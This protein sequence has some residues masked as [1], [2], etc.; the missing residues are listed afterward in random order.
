MNKVSIEKTE[1][2]I[3]RAKK[4][5]NIS[6]ILNVK[7]RPVNIASSAA[8]QTKIEPE[9]PLLSKTKKTFSISDVL[10][11]K[12]RPIGSS[13]MNKEHLSTGCNGA[14]CE[15]R[16]STYKE[17]SRKKT[18]MSKSKNIPMTQ[19][20]LHSILKRA[21]DDRFSRAIPTETAQIKTEPNSPMSD[22]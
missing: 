4:P 20:S 17:A 5:F 21:L 16:L 2:L 1:I 15:N 18:P 11:V 6:D 10:N 8:A 12:L 13:R 19:R 14:E 9:N 3:P 22:W 7:L